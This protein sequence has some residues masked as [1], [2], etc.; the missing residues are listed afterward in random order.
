M[1]NILVAFTAVA[2]ATFA[3]KAD[4]ADVIN[5]I[6]QGGSQLAIEYSSDG[7][8]AL[9]VSDTGR[10]GL[11]DTALTAQPVASGVLYTGQPPVMVNDPRFKTNGFSAVQLEAS[12]VK[13]TGSERVKVGLTQG[14][15]SFECEASG[16]S[17]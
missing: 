1:K 5:Y 9:I 11:A 16:A 14:R 2:I 10:Q 6:C 8:T 13:V 4:A 12:L 3:A 15:R 7:K 17:N